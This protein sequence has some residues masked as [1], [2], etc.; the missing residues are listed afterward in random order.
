MSELSN[1]CSS[2]AVSNS[3]ITKFHEENFEFGEHIT[4][5]NMFQPSLLY[6]FLRI[7]QQSR[8]LSIPFKDKENGVKRVTQVR[9]D[10]PGTRTKFFQPKIPIFSPTTVISAVILT[11]KLRIYSNA[12]DISGDNLS[13]TQ[14][15]HF[16]MLNFIHKKHEVNTENCMSLN[17]A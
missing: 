6:L 11:I 12:V 1:L 3:E 17:L 4:F 16:L 10:N 14:I 8:L 5:Y 13:M 9:N 15:S 2:A 7:T